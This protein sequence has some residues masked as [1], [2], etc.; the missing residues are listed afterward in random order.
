MRNIL[1]TSLS[2]VRAN[3]NSFGAWRSRKSA[4]PESFSGGLSRWNVTCG[5]S[6]RGGVAISLLPD[7]SG[8]TVR[9]DYDLGNEGA[10]IPLLVCAI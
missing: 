2:A 4:L 6:A 10:P 5:S 1:P 7:T 8:A 3:R 9:A